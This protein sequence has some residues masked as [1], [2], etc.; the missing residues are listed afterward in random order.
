MKCQPLIS[1]KKIAGTLGRSSVI[2]RFN[3]SCTLIG[4]RPQS[5]TGHIVKRYG[6]V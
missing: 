6:K 3:F 4:N 5:L 1:G 2:A